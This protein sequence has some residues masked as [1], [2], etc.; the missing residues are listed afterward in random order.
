MEKSLLGD[1]GIL[2]IVGEKLFSWGS[3]ETLFFLLRLLALLHLLVELVAE[4]NFLLVK[5]ISLLSCCLVQG[6]FNLRNNIELFL[7]LILSL[8]ENT[9]VFVI[10]LFELLILD[11]T[12]HL[13][14]MI[15]IF[16]VDTHSFA[17]LTLYQSVEQA[18]FSCL[19]F[20]VNR[21][22]VCPCS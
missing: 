4:S 15:V 22:G 13:W 9:R 11:G 3:A 5:N 8:I 7:L 20:Q 2:V 17:V 1:N 16:A 21:V 18:R 10:G 14:Y 19:H 6:L 12:M